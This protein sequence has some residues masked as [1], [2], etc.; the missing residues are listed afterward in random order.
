MNGSTITSSWGATFSSVGTVEVDPDF[1]DSLISRLGRPTFPWVSVR[2][3][4]EG[5][6]AIPELLAVTGDEK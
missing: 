5:A 4:E 1:C 3:A 2:R 6:G